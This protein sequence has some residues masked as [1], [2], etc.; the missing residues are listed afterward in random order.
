MDGKFTTIHGAV[1]FILVLFLFCLVVQAAPSGKRIP[2]ITIREWVTQDPPNLKDMTGTVYVVEFWA[3]WCAPCVKSIPHLISLYDKYRDDG[4]EFISLS[5]DKST[6][7]VR[8]FVAEKSI[9]YHVAI[10][11]GSVNWFEIRGYPTIVLVDHQGREAWRGHP[12]DGDFEKAIKTALAKAPPPL[13]I[14]VELGPFSDLKKELAGGKGFAR[15]YEKIR[16][17]ISSTNAE[18]KAAAQAIILAIDR[19]ISKKADEAAALSGEDP[20]AALNIYA[21]LIKRYDGV[22]VVKGAKAAYARIQNDPGLKRQLLAK[23]PVPVEE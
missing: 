5:Q 22:E 7:T 14:G 6:E 17:N 8:R 12:W 9:N 2:E 16:S 19:G 23:R 3:T 20:V 13:L 18:T 4:L 10:D 1:V 15:A 21:G 11:K